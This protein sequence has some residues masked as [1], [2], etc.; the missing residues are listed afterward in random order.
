MFI[1]YVGASEC[2]DG[3]TNNCT[4]I[5]TRNISDGISSYECSCNTGYVPNE[6]TTNLCDG[7]LA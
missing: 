7:K 6:N 2:Q 4:Q 1:L 3:I 5:C